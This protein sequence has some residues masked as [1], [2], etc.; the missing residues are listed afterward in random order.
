L[1]DVNAYGHAKRAA[2]RSIA[3]LSIY[4]KPRSARCFFGLIC[5]PAFPVRYSPETQPFRKRATRRLGGNAA[6]CSHLSRPPGS[7]RRIG[8]SQMGLKFDSRL[9]PPPKSGQADRRQ[10]VGS[11]PMPCSATSKRTQIALASTVEPVLH[12][13]V[14][15]HPRQSPRELRP[16]G[17]P[18]QAQ[19]QG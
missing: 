6:D 4:L 19:A 11:R 5:G 16:P 15:R 18:H 1:A 17:E 7:W 2:A 10:R 13:H 8:P 12:E 9:P 14:L 3:A